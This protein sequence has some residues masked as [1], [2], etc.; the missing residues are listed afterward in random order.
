MT[1]PALTFEVKDE[2]TIVMF[3]HHAQ[4]SPLGSR[5]RHRRIS[6]GTDFER[7]PAPSPLKTQSNAAQADADPDALSVQPQPANPAAAAASAQDAAAEGLPADVRELQDGRG[8]A[9]EQAADGGLQHEAGPAGERD[10]ASTSDA[11]QTNG[12]AD[13]SQAGIAGSSKT[14]PGATAS[15]PLHSRAGEC[16]CQH[17]CFGCSDGLNCVSAG[18]SKDAEGGHGDDVFFTPT[19][20]QIEEGEEQDVAEGERVESH[21][22]SSPLTTPVTMPVP[23]GQT[24]G[25]HMPTET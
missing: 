9:S 13:S 24:G 8:A 10:A 7:T 15:R 25:R 16:S 11:A 19:K 21:P 5:R 6:S 4:A 22:I 12:R 14:A 20:R 17:D 2:G 3:L 23:N 18:S 1:A